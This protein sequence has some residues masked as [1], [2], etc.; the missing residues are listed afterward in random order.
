LRKAGSQEAQY[1]IDCLYP[2]EIGKIARRNGVRQYLLVSSLGADAG[3]SNFYLKTKG[4]LENKIRDLGFET[5][6]SARPSLLLGERS[7]FRAGERIGIFLTQIFSLL[8]PRRYRGI[9]AGQV[10]RALIASANSD[11]KGVIYVE[12]DRLQDF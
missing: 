7:E 2:Y 4:E 11:L 10:A 1:R 8:I 6:V 12:S 9:R 3:S 5:F